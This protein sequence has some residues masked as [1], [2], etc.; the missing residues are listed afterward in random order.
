MRTIL[1]LAL[2]SLA[3]IG[4]QTQTWRG[5][6]YEA[7]TRE[8]ASVWQV[9][10][11]LVEVS[12]GVRAGAGT[13]EDGDLSG[14]DDYLST[15]TAFHGFLG[16]MMNDYWELGLFVEF[17][18]E[19]WEGDNLSF[20]ADVEGLLWG[21]KLIH[22]FSNVSTDVVPFVACSVG[23]GSVEWDADGDTED[24]ER[25]MAG[26]SVGVRIFGWDRFGINFELYYRYMSD[27]F[28]DIDL[29]EDINEIGG[30]LSLSYFF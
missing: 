17:L 22:N 23:F 26:A 29:R 13:I 2:L 5:T 9:R 15:A 19:S 24:A 8:S 3:T 28:D 12:A 21:A 7:G 10:S 14:F 27:D 30:I 25:F 18:E 11:G 16:Y 1:S 20:D 4:C 6:S